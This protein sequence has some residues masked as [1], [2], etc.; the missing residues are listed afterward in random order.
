MNHIIDN[1][2]VSG[3]DPASQKKLLQANKI[4]TIINCAP[5][6]CENYFNFISYMSYFL[7]DS[8]QELIELFFYHFVKFVQETENNILVHCQQGV[9]RSVALV[10]AYLMVVYK[11]SFDQALKFV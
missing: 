11:Y 6:Y 9:S 2:F 10:M 3:M 1:L 7:N 5:L 4:H 8:K